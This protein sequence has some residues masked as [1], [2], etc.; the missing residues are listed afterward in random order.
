MSDLKQI[1]EWMV[2]IITHPKGAVIGAE[3]TSINDQHWNIQSVVS[4]SNKLTSEQRIGIY[5]NGYFARLIECFKVEYQG[6]LNALGEEL[7]QHFAWNFLLKH[8]S[9]SYTLNDLGKLFPAYLEAT[10]LED[11]GTPES[12]QLFI[13]DVAK[14][15]RTFTEVYNGEGHEV[16]LDTKSSNQLQVSPAI[17]ILDLIFPVAECIGHFRE[18]TFT[19]FPEPKV[20]HYVFTRQNYMVKV[21]RLEA[22]EFQALLKW[23]SGELGS[24]PE[25]YAQKWKAI[26]VL[27]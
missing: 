14:F 4:P 26:G 20:S 16:L 5:H 3:E 2:G 18:D 25:M 8:P 12:W 13:L 11:E 17:V 21:Y 9:T 22:E 1:Q 10:L 6:L 24:C 15:E 23:K 7:F 19:E 27:Y